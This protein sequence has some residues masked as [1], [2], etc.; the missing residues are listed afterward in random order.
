[1]QSEIGRLTL[2]VEQ[3]LDCPTSASHHPSEAQIM[4]ETLLV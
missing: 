1:M 2:L 4:E 3:F